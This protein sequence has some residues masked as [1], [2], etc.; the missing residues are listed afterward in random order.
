ME[1]V[2]SGSSGSDSSDSDSSVELAKPV[3]IK[4]RKVE[5]ILQSK[6]VDP[7]RLDKYSIP[8][9]DQIGELLDD[10]DDLNPEEEYELWKLRE[11]TRYERDMTVLRERETQVGSRGPDVK[12]NR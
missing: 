10:T 9:D 5:E 3:F 4:K 12:T 6:E 1:E 11:L 2:T 7:N 8:E